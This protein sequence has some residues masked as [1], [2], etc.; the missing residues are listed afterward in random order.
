ML[1]TFT[2]IEGSF[3]P[4]AGFRSALLGAS[5]VLEGNA[6]RLASPERQPSA[7]WLWNRV[8]SGLSVTSLPQP[9]KSLF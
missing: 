9:A 8:R 2:V 4:G 7:G 1:D 6:W 3:C 5:L